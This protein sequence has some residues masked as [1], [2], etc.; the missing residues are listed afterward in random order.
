MIDASVVDQIRNDFPA[1]DR[2]LQ[3]LAAELL[4]HHR[5]ADWLTDQFPVGSGRSARFLWMHF[6]AQCGPMPSTPFLI[7]A[8]D[9]YEEMANGR[10]WTIEHRAEIE[11]AITRVR[12]MR[13]LKL[14]EKGAMQ[15][16]HE[17]LARAR[18]RGLSEL[19]RHRQWCDG[20]R[21][22]SE[23]LNLKWVARHEG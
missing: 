22:L 11:A 15:R 21:T 19:R 7:Y 13:T 9:Q 20:Q 16:A 4:S 10:L 2:Y 8:L 5:Q 3:G 12:S 18:V 1:L 14:L 17:D 23:L 6:H